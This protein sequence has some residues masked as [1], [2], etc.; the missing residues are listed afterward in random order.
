MVI[1]FLT[2]LCAALH[3]GAGYPIDFEASEPGPNPVA[4]P[5]LELVEEAKISVGVGRM[6]HFDAPWT[7]AGVSLTDP[8]VADIDVLTDQLLVV[9]GRAP[10]VTDLLLWSPTGQVE[11][12]RVEVQADLELIEEELAALFPDSRISLRQAQNLTFLSG[13]LARAEQVER[14]EAYMQAA[15][16]NYIDAVSVAGVQ[17]VQVQVR[18]AEVSRKGLRALGVNGFATSDSGFVGNTVGSAA[19]GPVNPFSIGPRRGHR[20][21]GTLPFIYNDS[22]NLSPAVTLFGGVHGDFE[23]FVKALQENQ[24]L[25]VLAE[26]NLIALS[27]ETASFLAGGEFPVPVV[28][29]VSGAATVTVEFKEFGVGLRFTPTVL[30]DGGLRLHVASE[31]S[32]LSNVGA[33]LVEG[34]HIP[35]VVTRRAETTLEM[36]SGQTF[37]MAGLLNE[38]STAIASEIP[39]LAA[40]PILG[41]LFRSVSYQRG[42]TELLLLVTA[43]LVEP[44]SDPLLPPLPGTDHIEPSDW[45]LYATGRLEGKPPPRLA[46]EDQAWISKR[47][48]D[49][50]HGPGAWAT[51]DQAPA[52]SQVDTRDE[53]AAPKEG[54]LE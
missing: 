8:G 24:Y 50:L 45:E 43:S 18:V 22:A 47:G 4:A 3:A 7:I 23:I 17:Q 34:F 52:R 54:T 5:V 48:L 51:H 44:L 53:S 28:Q 38:R 27:G 1:P 31:V 46:P 16:L 19:G 35:S 12:M 21:D 13:T 9:T 6:R 11:S 20:A 26:P 39:G 30:G 10:G 29:G 32:D 2:V 40:V 14:L 33:V 25:R 41:S 37:A 42:E 49:R 36:K 15:G